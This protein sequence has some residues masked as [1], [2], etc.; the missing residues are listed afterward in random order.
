MW[1]KQLEFRGILG[2]DIGGGDIDGGREEISKDLSR[3]QCKNNGLSQSKT[4]N[5]GTLWSRRV[6]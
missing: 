2:E 6:K 5:R 4:G 3:S 1:L